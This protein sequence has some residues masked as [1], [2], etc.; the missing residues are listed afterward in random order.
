MNYGGVHDIFLELPSV[1]KVICQE[2]APPKKKTGI[3]WITKLPLHHI[4]LEQR[5]IAVAKVPKG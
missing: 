3:V 2:Y 5:K 1:K 4:L